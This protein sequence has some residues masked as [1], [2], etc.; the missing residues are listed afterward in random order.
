MSDW[1]HYGYDASTDTVED[2]DVT[3]CPRCSIPGHS[4]TF[5]GGKCPHD[6]SLPANVIAAHFKERNPD[7]VGIV[8]EAIGN[9]AVRALEEA[10]YEI[11]GRIGAEDE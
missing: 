1:D 8:W 7:Y 4:S 9:G 10:G 2:L 6:P 3:A 5:H 11:V